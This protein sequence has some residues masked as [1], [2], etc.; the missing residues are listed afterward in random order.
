MDLSFARLSMSSATP[1][2]VAAPV[3]LSV[4]MIGAKERQD[5]SVTACLQAARPSASGTPAHAAP[6]DGAFCPETAAV[7]R[8]WKGP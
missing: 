5:A 7:L 1:L 2:L 6:A 8:R 3:D 4:L